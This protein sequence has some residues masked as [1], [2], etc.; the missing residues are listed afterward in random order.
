[1]LLSEIRKGDAI[2]VHK[3]GDELDGQFGEVVSIEGC[4]IG[5]IFSPEVHPGYVS[6][7]SDRTSFF[8]PEQLS[9][10]KGWDPMQRMLALFG[11][12]WSLFTRDS[13]LETDDGCQVKG[14]AKA[15]QRKGL[16]NLWGMVYEVDLCEEHFDQ[17]HGTRRDSF[18][19]PEKCRV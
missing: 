5:V 8:E 6:L 16:V 10:G 19:W 12:A 11:S 17:Y 2:V 13:S 7:P 14:C 18:P 3:N 15:A 9:E 1:M 4:K